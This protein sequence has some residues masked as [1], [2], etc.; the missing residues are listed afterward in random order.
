MKKVLVLGI[1]GML[2]HRVFRE[3]RDAQDFDV[4]GTL[5]SEYVKLPT[6]HSLFENPDIVLEKVEASDPMLLGQVISDLK[7]DF[8]INC[9]G[10]IKQRE[11]D[12]ENRPLMTAV[13]TMLP[14]ALQREVSTYGGK[15]I[16]ISSDCV[17]L[18]DK[19]RAY[20]E[21]DEPDAHSIYGRTKHL[22]EVVYG[23]A[24]TL[25]TSFI[26]FEVKGFMSL[27]E[28]FFAAVAK[29]RNDLTQIHGFTQAVWSGVT[30]KFMAELLVDVVRNH[31]DLS[32]L[33]HVASNPVTKYELLKL[34]S[35]AFKLEAI[36][37]RDSLF[38]PD[39]VC[40]RW[41]LG[42]K[43]LKATSIKIPTVEGLIHE[44]K[45]DLEF[46]KGHRE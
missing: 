19:A 39:K 9:I 21:D 22:G 27:L 6:Y 29:Q 11:K 25:R 15:L 36:I 17:F 28:W 24:L 12:S 3:F 37:E 7:P 16:T 1:D 18:G 45:S 42:T 2:G 41:L 30:T 38:I 20:T 32:G 31:A 43:F 40:N 23:N 10:I 8:V 4:V 14:H 44:L 5:R 26:G 33:F 13:N 34:I 46:Y 35:D